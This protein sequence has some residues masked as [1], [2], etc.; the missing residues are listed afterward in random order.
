MAKEE[1]EFFEV[2]TKPWRPVPGSKCPGLFERI[3]AGDPSSNDYTRMLRF[4]PGVDTTPNGVQSHEFW[5]EV[6]ILEGSI[7]DLNLNQEFKAGTYACR[8]PGMLH[9]PWKSPS[10]CITFESRYTK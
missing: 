1:L 2:T 7:V 3:L 5:E 6:Y 8:P 10:G 9:G 4:E